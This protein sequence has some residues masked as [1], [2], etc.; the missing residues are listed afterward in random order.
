MDRLST[1][2]AQF[3]MRATT[4]YAGILN[5]DIAFDAQERSGKLYLFNTGKARFYIAKREI[6]ISQ[7]ILLFVPRPCK[8]HLSAVA[9]DN[10]HQVSA[11]VSSDGGLDNPLTTALPD[12][13][14]FPLSQLPILVDSVLWLFSEAAEQ[15][16]GK[17][18]VL[19]RLFELVIIQL[20]RHIMASSSLSSGM[21]AGLAD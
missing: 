1:L 21:M 12:Y 17:N 4:F 5:G 2:L 9:S 14:L 15:N 20:L 18:A 10:T 3:G 7:P 8:H 13:M 6:I 16:C 11:T 19:N